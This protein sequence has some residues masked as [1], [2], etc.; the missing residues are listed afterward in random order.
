MYESAGQRK[1][2]QVCVDL[3][4][5]LRYFSIRRSFR[6]TCA[7]VNNQRPKVNQVANQNEEKISSARPNGPTIPLCKSPLLRMDTLWWLSAKHHRNWRLR[8]E[9]LSTTWDFQTTAK[10]EAQKQLHHEQYQQHVVFLVPPTRDCH[11]TVVEP[12]DSCFTEDSFFSL[13]EFRH[14]LLH[15]GNHSTGR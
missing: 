7:V 14:V 1:S 11:L 15:C 8:H 6:C 10:Q 4:V 13:L 2:R 9:Q 12:W 5:K 3:N